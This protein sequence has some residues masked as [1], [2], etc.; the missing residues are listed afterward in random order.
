MSMEPKFLRGLRFLEGLAKP[1]RAARTFDWTTSELMMA[2]RSALA[3]KVRGRV[4]VFF[5]SE[6]AE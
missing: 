1:A 6:A 5:T 2:A 4:K 3:I